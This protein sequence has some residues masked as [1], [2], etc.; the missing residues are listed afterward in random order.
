MEG[1]EDIRGGSMEELPVG[2]AVG[3]DGSCAQCVVETAYAQGGEAVMTDDGIGNGGF[4]HH[5]KRDMRDKERRQCRERGGTSTNSRCKR[6]GGATRE[7]AIQQPTS[8][9]EAH[10]KERDGGMTREGRGGMARFCTGSTRKGDAARQQV[11]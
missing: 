2:L 11:I 10:R 1:C 6:D 8:T 7:E 4:E 5:A 3:G 9:R